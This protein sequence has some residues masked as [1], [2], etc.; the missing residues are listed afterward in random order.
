M[1]KLVKRILILSL[2][3]LFIILGI[4]G[5][6]LPVL[7]GIFFLFIGVFLLSRES[8][9]VHRQVEKL[10]ERYP[11]FGHYMDKAGEKVREWKKRVMG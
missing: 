7:Q 10:R 11:R 5:L 8:E 9:T 4:A 1:K 6:F 2:G 3:W